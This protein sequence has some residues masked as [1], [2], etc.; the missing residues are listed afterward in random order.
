MR[1]S[2]RPGLLP[3]G[4]ATAG[5]AGACK[6]CAHGHGWRLQG[7]RP[8]RVRCQP[9]REATAGTSPVGATARGVVAPVRP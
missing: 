5:M 6:G 7:R 2:P 1:N 3:I 4:A 9:T 8:L